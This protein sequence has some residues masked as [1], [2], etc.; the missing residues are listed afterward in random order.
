MQIVNL[1]FEL[2]RQ[3]IKI[4]TFRYGHSGGK[5]GGIDRYPLAWL[6]DPIYIRNINNNALQYT[7]NLDILGVPENSNEVPTLQ[8]V[9]MNV[10]LSFIEKIKKTANATG[11]FVDSFSILS[12]REYFDD[13]AAGCRF[14]LYVNGVNPVDLC[15]D[16]FDE[17]KQFEV[18]NLLPN[19]DTKGAEGCVVFSDKK[20]LPN[21]KI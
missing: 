19:F 9:A 1:F 21:F 4:K 13:N 16:N 3:H 5:G 17:N 15:A 2:S 12:L 11:F 8:G 10:G 6:D 14:T 7:V 18:S 20:T